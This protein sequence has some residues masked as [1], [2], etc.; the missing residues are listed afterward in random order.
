MTLTDWIQLTATARAEHAEQVGD[1]LSA[2]GALAVTVHGD[3]TQDVLEPLPGTT[4]L[5][6][7]NKV[8]GLFAA[9]TPME[10]VLA[11]LRADAGP[12][13][14][15]ECTVT[16]LA[17]QAWERACL[18]DFK[19]MRFGARTWVCPSWGE[20]PP[21]PD[22]VILHL[23]PGLAF[24]TGSH[25]STALCLT[26]LDAHPPAGLT[27]VDYGC[28]S[29]ILGICAAKYGAA[30]V[31]CVDYD[32]QALLATR[33]NAKHNDVA[34]HIET[35]TPEHD[36]DIRAQVVLANILAAPLIELAPR[37]EAMLQP[38]G[39]IVLAGLLNDQAAAIVD[40]YRPWV[41]LQIADTRDGWA[42]LTGRRAAGI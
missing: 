1:A 9:G 34:A 24:G 6:E 15:G 22:A 14:I 40:A 32:P 13:L 27:V 30:R 36:G 29:G 37:F 18:N 33:N 35:R 3:D 4:P 26:W 19:P 20:L 7:H 41:E 38:G 11:R 23:D 5:W 28:G 25:A 39:H 12:A 16:T 2:A 8:V 21:Q 31:W 42:L 17:D 10:P